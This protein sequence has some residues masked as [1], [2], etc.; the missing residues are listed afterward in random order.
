MAALAKAIPTWPALR[1]LS[2]MTHVVDGLETDHLLPLRDVVKAIPV[3]NDSLDLFLPAFTPDAIKRIPFAPTLRELLIANRPVPLLLVGLSSLIPRLPP[4]LVTLTLWD[5]AF[6]LPDVVD[7]LVA[8]DWRFV[9]HLQQ[10]GPVGVL[11]NAFATNLP[12]LTTLHLDELDGTNVDLAGWLERVPRSVTRLSVFVHQLMDV[13]ADALITRYSTLGPRTN[14]APRVHV[15]VSECS[16]SPLMQARLCAT[17]GMN[18][19]LQRC[20]VQGCADIIQ[21]SKMR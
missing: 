1:S 11:L 7:P 8:L 17:P 18:V 9:A 19:T 15:I 13:I 2:V 20:L 5:T 21:L 3:A 6:S 16:F 14:G 4:S 10:L 12:H